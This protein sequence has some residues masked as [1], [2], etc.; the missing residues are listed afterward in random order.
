M[1]NP[2][3]PRAWK[4]SASVETWT[5][6][7]HCLALISA[8]VLHK[9]RKAIWGNLCWAA[10]QARGRERRCVIAESE[11][12]GEW[13]GNQK[14]KKTHQSST[15]HHL[16]VKRA[17][18]KRWAAKGLAALCSN[19]ANMALKGPLEYSSAAAQHFPTC[20]SFVRNVL[21]F[22][23]YNL[24]T[25]FVLYLCVLFCFIPMYFVMF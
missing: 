13:V 20:T 12:N 22:F 4:R 1:A 24:S 7:T 23:C 19:C 9:A 14:G 17:R 18:S 11:P 3:E 25:D 2:I 15:V 6:Q 16:H 10:L 21:I 5:A 8:Q